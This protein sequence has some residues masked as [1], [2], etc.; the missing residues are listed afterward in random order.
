MASAILVLFGSFEKG[1]ILEL[2]F[3]K[4][5]LE[6]LGGRS[7]GMY[8]IHRPVT[9]IVQETTFRFKFDL[10]NWLEANQSHRIFFMA[11]SIFITVCIAEIFYRIL[12][13]P[14]IDKGSVLVKSFKSDRTQPLY[15]ADS[16]P[17]T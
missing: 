11:T 10:K 14:F 16:S 12:E 4:G 13:K 6:Y 8:L 3:L 1:L 2:P 17:S 7:Y 5:I 9:W 15:G